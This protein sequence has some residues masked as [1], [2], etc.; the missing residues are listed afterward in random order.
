MRIV[1]A[2]GGIAGLTLAA[3]LR[4][5]GREPIVVEK[6]ES[7]D[8]VGYAIGLWPLGSCVLHGLGCFD[9]LLAR[10]S[11]P[12]IYE[13]GDHRGRVLQRVPL[14]AVT[15][16]AGAPIL[17][18][19][20]SDLVDILVSVCKN[21]DLRMSTTIS[22][23]EQNDDVVAVSLSSGETIE[24]DVLVLAEGQ[25]SP[26]RESVFGPVET[27][28]THWV[29]WTWWGK[30]GLLPATTLR[31]FW[32]PGRLFGMYPC[33]GRVAVGAGFPV[34]HIAPD[35][36]PTTIRSL[37][38]EANAE[39]CEADDVIAAFIDD[40]EEFF[41]WPMTDLRVGNWSNG[42]VVVCGDAGIAFLPTAGV[43]ASNALR[44]AAALAD[45]LSRADA[46]SVELA[47]EL[48]EKRCR[49]IIEGNQHDSRSLARYMFIENRALSWARDQ[50][51]RHYPPTKMV[52]QIVDSMHTPF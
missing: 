47:L 22:A 41:P 45:E 35:A 11:Q 33:P 43:G 9:E 21:V 39:L 15:E 28:D 12:E 6:A 38:Q 31:E 1:I 25:H 27:F 20:R 40:A 19:A 52:D 32:G 44:S 42:R 50:M 26:T 24:A 48:Y 16:G 37:I 14:S 3:K 46:K 8:Q 34:D 23:V 18:V 30:D 51:L 49:H 36:D 29:I 5:Q 13:F 4:Q 17:Q 7:Y 10:S 2:G